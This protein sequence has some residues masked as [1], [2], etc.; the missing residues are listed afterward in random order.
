M[1]SSTTAAPAAAGLQGLEAC[2]GLSLVWC[3]ADLDGDDFFGL[4]LESLLPILKTLPH[5]LT[6]KHLHGVFLL[7]YS[8]MKEI[9]LPVPHIARDYMLLVE[10]LPEKYA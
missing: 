2:L 8:D 5:I 10:T 7:F 4:F 9:D 3:C 1:D 6:T